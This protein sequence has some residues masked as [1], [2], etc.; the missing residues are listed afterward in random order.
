MKF[1]YD[2]DIE[3]PS[4]Q[5]ADAKANALARLAQQFDA[6]TLAALASK[7]A[8]FL[9]DPVFGGMIRSQLGLQ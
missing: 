2:I 5:E 6:R 3:A 4:Q 9:K 7:G 8:G 1:P